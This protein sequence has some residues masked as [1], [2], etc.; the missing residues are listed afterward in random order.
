MPMPVFGSTRVTNVKKK[1]TKKP[2]ASSKAKNNAIRNILKSHLSEGE[3]TQNEC[4]GYKVNEFHHKKNDETIVYIDFD[5]KEL[6]INTDIYTLFSRRFRSPYSVDLVTKRIKEALKEVYEGHI[7][8][9]KMSELEDL[10]YVDQTENGWTISTIRSE[11]KSASFKKIYQ[12]NLFKKIAVYTIFIM[13]GIWLL[14][15]F[16]YLIGIPIYF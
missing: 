15:V 3:I 5:T 13:F 16:L 4:L 7:S 11:V 10:D 6:V 9:E 14:R 12:A 2:K 1:T 8:Q